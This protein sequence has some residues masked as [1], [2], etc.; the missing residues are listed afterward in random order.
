MF[1]LGVL[2]TIDELRDTGN[3]PRVHGNGFIQLDLTD[4]LRLHVWGQPTIPRQRVANTVHDHVFGF[5]SM[6]H[7]GR[8][9][10]IN[11]DSVSSY[12]G[13]YCLWQAQ[14]SENGHDTQLALMDVP[15]VK[16]SHKGTGEITAGTEHNTYYIF[17]FRFHE[18]VATEPSLTIIEKDGDTLVQDP[19]GYRPRVCVPVG[20]E[21]DN[22]FSRVHRSSSNGHDPILLWMIIDDT[23]RKAL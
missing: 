18:T 15:P 13:D 6:C 12:K 9:L 2:P 19:G 4:R 16:L 10:N 23:L 5:R 21:P 17:P 20:V 14:P 11:W 8:V 22:E 3:H 7:I 1:S